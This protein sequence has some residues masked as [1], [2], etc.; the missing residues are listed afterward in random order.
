M[1]TDRSD[2]PT[3]L[4]MLAPSWMPSVGIFAVCVMSV[5]DPVTS[6][7]CVVL[8]WMLRG[9]AG[10][11]ARTDYHHDTLPAVRRRTADQALGGRGTGGVPVGHHA[12]AMCRDSGNGI[13]AII[14]LARLRALLLLDDCRE[15]D[16]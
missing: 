3:V 10:G 6:E 12:R 13:L 14:A 16:G 2:V 5:V 9:P 1:S 4:R 7:H 15:I 8:Q 11:L